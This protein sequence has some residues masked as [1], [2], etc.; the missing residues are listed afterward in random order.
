METITASGGWSQTIIEMP[1]ENTSYYFSCT[2]YVDCNIEKLYG[3]TLKD[4]CTTVSQ[5]TLTLTS[6]TTYTVPSGY[7]SADIFCVGGGGGGAYG[8]EIP[9][10]GG[11]GGC[12]YWD[13][14]DFS[15]TL[16]KATSGTANTGGG[17]GGGSYDYMDYDGNDDAKGGTGGSGIIIIRFK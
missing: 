3:N 10:G 13:S 11:G 12:I 14:T 7:T 17:G 15:E 4:S 16:V 5:K 2:A 8:G 1:A 6:S 9:G